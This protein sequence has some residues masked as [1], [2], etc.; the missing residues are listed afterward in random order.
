MYLEGRLLG[1]ILELCR[2]R[3]K[4]LYSSRNKSQIA[5]NEKVFFHENVGFYL[6]IPLKVL[7]SHGQNQP[8]G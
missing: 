8:F 3:R 2:T 6:I 1:H 4:R 5:P 7:I